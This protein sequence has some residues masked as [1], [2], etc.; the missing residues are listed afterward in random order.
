MVYEIRLNSPKDVKNLNDA[1]FNYDGK[2]TVSS[3]AVTVDAKSILALFA[4]IGKK[5]IKLVAPDH[6]KHEKFIAFLEELGV[7]A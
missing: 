6:E 1:A 4:L 7:L 5:N 3:G 2:L